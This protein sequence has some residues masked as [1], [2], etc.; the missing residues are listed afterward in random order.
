MGLGYRSPCCREWPYYDFAIYTEM[1]S[2]VGRAGLHWS[3][4]LFFFIYLIK[5]P[6]ELQR[7]ALSS[8]Y[9]NGFEM[10]VVLLIGQRFT[11]YSFLPLSQIPL[12]IVGL[13]EE[14]FW[15]GGLVLREWHPLFS[16]PHVCFRPDWK[17]CGALERARQ[18]TGDTPKVHAICILMDYGS[19][20]KIMSYSYNVTIQSMCFFHSDLP[21]SSCYPTTLP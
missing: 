18:W 9:W 20:S 7:L 17:V 14:K 4:L 2:S 12:L 19:S 3:D 16:L 6:V 15:D 1:W 8:V 13:R 21:W 5:R 11:R 10:K